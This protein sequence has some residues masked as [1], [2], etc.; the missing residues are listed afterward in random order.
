MQIS[1]E[2]GR[3]SKNRGSAAARGPGPE[4][5]EERVRLRARQLAVVHP[6]HPDALIDEAAFA[7][8]E[9]LPYW[10]E[11]WPSGLALGRALDRYE[12]AR[13]RVVELGCG[14]AVPSIAAALAGARVLAT[15]WSTD[16][17]GF[18][19]E[20]AAR[21]GV[22]LETAVVAWQDPLPLTTRGEWDVV[23]AADLLYE[24]R[25]VPLILELL[26]RLVNDR[27]RVLLADPGRPAAQTF[28]AAAAAHWRIDPLERDPEHP[29]V[30]LYELTTLGPK[31]AL[32]GQSAGTLSSAE[33][34]CSSR[35]SRTASSTGPW[36]AGSPN[37][38]SPSA[39]S[40]PPMVTPAL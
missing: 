11:L 33:D 10:A 25:N 1:P 12:L 31:P 13:L 32:E 7:R 9:F 36:V 34:G 23:L 21:N 39:S 26:P 38:T 3:S 24:N 5:V 40:A 27:G 29:R 19:R 6:R 8:E 30:E 4:L 14:L 18:A 37:S 15:D 2:S 28:L 35:R 16:A 22:A 20:N 17:L